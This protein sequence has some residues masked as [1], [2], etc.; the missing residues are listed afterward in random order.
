MT[1]RISKSTETK[2]LSMHQAGG[3]T[4]K[5]IGDAADVSDATVSAVL[6]RNGVVEPRGYGGRGGQRKHDFSKA[7]INKITRMYGRGDSCETIGSA[8]GVSGYVIYKRLQEIG[9]EIRPAGFQCG[10]AHHAW[11]GGRTTRADGYVQVM[12]K[13]DDPFFEMGHR[14][15]EQDSHRYALEHRLVM[16]HHI[17]RPLRDDETV[18]HIDGNRSNNDITNL[19]LRVGKHGKGAVACCGDCGSRN[20]IHIT[21]H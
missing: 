2:I 19:Q 16:A 4:Y 11:T 17:G 9:V 20:V 15:N 12:L 13:P 7:Q 18:H 14:R 10:E 8:F 5:E 3:K 1:K 21:L 6:H